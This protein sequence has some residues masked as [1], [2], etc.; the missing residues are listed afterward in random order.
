MVFLVIFVVVLLRLLS[1][2]GQLLPWGTLYPIPA[3]GWQSSGRA[4]SGPKASV[5]TVQ[6]SV[7][8]LTVLLVV[9]ISTTSN[10]CIWFILFLRSWDQFDPIFRL[11]KIPWKHATV[12]SISIF[13]LLIALLKLWTHAAWIDHKIVMKII[14]F[15]SSS[16][17][18]QPL[19]KNQ[20]TL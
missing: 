8:N 11:R 20:S 13:W 18:V 9:L 6:M 17:N 4:C 14:A 2:G 15:R 16:R 10:I 7:R 3:G 12:R 1:S 19:L 5:M